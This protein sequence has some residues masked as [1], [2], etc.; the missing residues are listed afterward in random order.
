MLGHDFGPSESKSTSGDRN[1]RADT[2][3]GM[4]DLVASG[5]LPLLSEK[6]LAA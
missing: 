5:W 2:Q 3:A 4:F 6:P 1:S